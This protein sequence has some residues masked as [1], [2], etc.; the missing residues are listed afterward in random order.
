MYS[1]FIELQS[2]P[3]H[4]TA[5]DFAITRA[6]VWTAIPPISLPL[7]SISHVVATLY[8][9][10]RPRGIAAGHASKME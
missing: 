10:R 9:V 8:G 5:P 2:S 6:A 7:T 3:G 4:E 1:P